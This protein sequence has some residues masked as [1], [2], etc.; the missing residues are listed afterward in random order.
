MSKVKTIK[1]KRGIDPSEVKDIL[2]QIC[3]GMEYIHKN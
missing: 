3:G 1:F 2:N